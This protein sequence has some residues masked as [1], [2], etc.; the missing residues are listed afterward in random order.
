[1]RPATFVPD[2]KPVDD[3]LREM[4]AMQTHVAIVIDE[5]GGTAGLVAIQGNFQ[6]IGG[7]I[8]DEDDQERPPVERVGGGPARVTPPPCGD[9][10]A[11]R[12]DVTGAAVGVE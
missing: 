8:A 9:T 12:F 11:A 10:P 3:L 7:G 5:Y 6:E 1:M 2:S 4:Q